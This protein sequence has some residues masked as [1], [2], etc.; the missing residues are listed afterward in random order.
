MTEA[1]RRIEQAEAALELYGYS[2]LCEPISG[3]ED[4][5]ADALWAGVARIEAAMGRRRSKRAL[6]VVHKSIPSPCWGV[7]ISDGM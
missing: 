3:K 2:V 7:V 6:K 1:N 5:Y 4:V